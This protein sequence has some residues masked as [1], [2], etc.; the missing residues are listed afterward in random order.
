MTT[1]FP[2]KTAP[3]A[4][5]LRGGY[6]T[7]DPIARFIARWAS[8]AGPRTLEPSAGDGAILRYLS[9]QSDPLAVEIDPLE[10]AAA[11]ERTS[12]NVIN[13]DFF[14]WFDPIHYSS[15]D[16]VA[17]NPPYIRFGN[18]P[19]KQREKALN[20]MGHSGFTPSRLTNAWLPFVVASVHAVRDGGRIGLVL[21]A[22]LLQVDYARE[23]RAFLEE[24]CSR[25]N[26]VSFRE[27]VFPSVQ[28]EVVLLL[29][30]KGSSQ[31]EIHA[32]ELE[33]LD[34]LS[35]AKIDS[36]S[37][38]VPI[39][40]GAKWTQFYLTEEE[41][42]LLRSVQDR[43]DV[44]TIGDYARVS[45]GVVTG[46]NSF[47]C[48]TDEEVQSLG[49]ER[50]TKP[51]VSRSNFLRSPIFTSVDLTEASEK[52]KTNLLAAPSNFDLTD[53][54]RLREYV[55]FGEEE[56]VHSGYKCKIRSPWWSVP[57]TQEPDGFMLR[58]ISRTLMVSAN[59]VG[60]TSTDTVHR[61]FL[62]DRQISPD[63]LAVAALNSLSFCSTEVTGRS[64]GGGVLE[65]EP[66]EAQKVLIPNPHLV[67]ESLKEEVDSLYRAG[68]QEE[69]TNLLD[70]EILVGRLG[71]SSEELT[72]IR[73]SHKKLM[74]RRLR[75]GGSR[76]AS[77]K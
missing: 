41:I 55:K 45:V 73:K 52:G 6:Y 71:L 22:E 42:D 32:F 26:L 65:L 49:I 21:P 61:V 62:K 66:R 15:F 34:C 17:G 18:W 54:S 72:M 38:T 2:G 20:F 75:R 35:F 30:E 69:A 13:A 53:D 58:Q 74:Q 37:P 11:Q 23:L 64:Y 1:A 46:R 47:F 43:S 36:G 68:N 63:L 24:S 33:S 57:S 76:R 67:S 56:G 70:E 39:D 60:A 25:I 8:E 14:D 7:P 29:A 59:H 3:T 10:A 5:K 40:Q 50:F 51:L 31:V 48:L 16:A 44:H 27:L 9:Q 19:T 4:Q 28:Q 12:A 77:S